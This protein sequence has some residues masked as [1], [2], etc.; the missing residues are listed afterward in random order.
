MDSKYTR[1]DISSSSPYYTPTSKKDNRCICNSD[2]WC[3]GDICGVFC[4]FFTWSLI[5]Y[6]EFVVTQVILLPTFNS[7]FSIINLLL[8]QMLTILAVASH[9]RAMLTD[10]GAVPRGNATKENIEKM[11]F[12]E[13]QVIFKCPKCSCIKPER[14]HHCSV[15]QRCVRKMDHHCPWVNNCVGEGN[16]K[17]FVLFTLY[18]ALMSIHA[19]FLA[20]AHFVDCLGSEWRKCTAYSPPATIILLLFL[21]FEGMLFAL[22]TSI[23][24]C[25]QLSAIWYDETGIE[26]LKNEEAIW[27]RNSQWKSFKA[28]FG[29]FSFEWFSPFTKVRLP[30]KSHG[31]LFSV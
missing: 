14:A 17:F 9:L 18:I 5:F 11:G 24:F 25:T 12:R 21:I 31:Y 20:L 19:L 1:L 27:H 26:S 7:T 4:A 15:C 29:H 8:F 10:P 30:G 3:V 13:G 22:F 16:Q 6:A 23:M 2:V 28:V